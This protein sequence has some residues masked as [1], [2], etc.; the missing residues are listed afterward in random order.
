MTSTVVITGGT[1]GIGHGLARAFLA[2]GCRVAVCGR[3]AAG[4]E[5]ALKSLGGGAHA[6]GHVA[7]VTDRDQV[8]GLWTAAE[9]AFGRVDVWINNAGATTARR[10]LWSLGPHEADGVTAV[11]LRGVVNGSAVAAERFLRQGSG[12]VWNMEGFGSDGRI[13]PGL[14]VYGA[15]KR[16]VSYLTGALAADLRKEANARPHDVRALLLSPGI[17]VTDL[18]LHDYTPDEYAKARAVLNILADRV[19]TVTPWLADRVL[20]DRTANGCRVAWLTRRKAAG[21]F[22]AAA[23]RKRSVLPEALP[24]ASS[25]AQEQEGT[26]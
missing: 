11:N 8:A 19:E 4:V 2:R 7:D 3:N 15:S 16:A 23:L 24:E 5:A 9:G 1:R 20:A 10:P 18:L 17:V 13:M 12:R 25:A 21:R 26:S 22:A 6:V 14:S